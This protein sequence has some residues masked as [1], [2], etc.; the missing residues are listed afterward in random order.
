MT[1]TGVVTVWTVYFIDKVISS[2]RAKKVV[3]DLD[4]NTYT[5]GITWI[6]TD[7]QTHAL[8]QIYSLSMCLS[9]VHT[10]TRGD[11]IRIVDLPMT[12]T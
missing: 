2:L 9:L 8:Y 6:D 7:K 10:Q 1:I 12:M 5:G 11:K 3:V 4:N